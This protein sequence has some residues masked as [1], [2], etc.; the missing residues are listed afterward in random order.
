MFKLI[1]F[2]RKRPS[3]RTIRI[4]RTLGWGGLAGLMIY[5]APHISLPFSGYYSDYEI[6]MIYAIAGIF[7]ILAVV[8]GV[9]GLCV[10]KRSIMKKVQMITGI[11]LVLLGSTISIIQSSEGSDTLPCSD[12]ETYNKLDGLPPCTE[13]VS[14]LD[15]SRSSS[16]SSP[17][18]P[19]IFLIL[20]GIMTFIGGVTGKM[21]TQSCMKYR[22]VITKI[23]V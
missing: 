17:L 7:V 5:T 23:R 12:T 1:E 16:S 19:S 6:Y 3:D 22:E 10:Y 21:V 18:S 4:L 15:L 13:E 9:L 2:L 11:L 8:F 14:L 20:I